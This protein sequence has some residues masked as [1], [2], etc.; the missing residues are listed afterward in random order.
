M[1]SAL[2]STWSQVDPKYHKCWSQFTA[3]VTA[4][5][6]LKYAYVSSPFLCTLFTLYI[7]PRVAVFIEP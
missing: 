7:V 3:A 5:L 4:R 2:T 1:I 6:P